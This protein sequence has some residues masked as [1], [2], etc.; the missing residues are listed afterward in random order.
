MKG[1]PGLRRIREKKGMS[2]EQMA[3]ALGM[4][5]TTYKHVEEQAISVKFDTLRILA[6]V[7]KCKEGDLLK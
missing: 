1:L 5:F 4:K 7:L 3:V 2:Q 6:E